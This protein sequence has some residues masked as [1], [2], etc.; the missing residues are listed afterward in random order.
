[1][2]ST[3]NPSSC[4]DEIEPRWRRRK[5]ARPQEILA[6][7]LDLFT[8]KGY[9]ATRAD[10][11]ATRA[12]VSKGTVYLYFENKEELFKAVVRESFGPALQEA[13]DLVDH[14]EG[15]SFDLLDELMCGWWQHVGATKAAGIMK[16][17]MAEAVNFPEIAKFYHDEVVA[18]A[19]AMVE[20][21]LARGIRNK[22]FRPL[23]LHHMAHVVSSPMLMLIIW[24]NSFGRCAGCVEL[25]PPT[26][27]ANALD[28]IKR[29]L[30]V[31]PDQIPPRA[32]IS[33]QMLA[34]TVAKRGK[35]SAGKAR[36]VGA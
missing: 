36:G 2:S 14:Y 33:A 24:G 18:R 26:H 12:G 1:M 4:A 13:V 23:D 31:D 32:A 27:I 34:E 7:A 8:E 19:H 5:D 21:L 16:L 20:K 29:G 22:E 10:E 3:V 28:L 35:H 11:V 25:D 6:A 17:M 30:A 15:S 9:A